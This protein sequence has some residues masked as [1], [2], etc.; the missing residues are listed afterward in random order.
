MLEELTANQTA[1]A[2]DLLGTDFVD[3]L[4]LESG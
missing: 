3:V 2:P 1:T 4:R